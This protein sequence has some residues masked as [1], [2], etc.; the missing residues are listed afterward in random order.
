[1]AISLGI[2]TH[3]QTYPHEAPSACRAFEEHTYLPI[4]PNSFRWALESPAPFL[5]GVSGSPIASAELPEDVRRPGGWGHGG[6]GACR[7]VRIV[8]VHWL[9]IIKLLIVHDDYHCHY[10]FKTH[11]TFI[12]GVTA[13]DLATIYPWWPFYCDGAIIIPWEFLSDPI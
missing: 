2:L 11:L 9:N 10:V 1:M 4:L 13:G 7:M 12:V 3:F 6:M 8:M 5:M